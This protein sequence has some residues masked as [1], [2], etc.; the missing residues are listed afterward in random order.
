MKKNLSYWE[1]E[2]IKFV[3]NKKLKQKGKT[4]Y[5]IHKEKIKKK[6]SLEK[7][8]RIYQKEYIRRYNKNRRKNDINFKILYNYR[9]R[10]RQALKQNRK[11]K[12]TEKLI[13]CNIDFLKYHLQKQFKKGMT[14]Q[15]YGKWHID[16][17]RP[18][19]SFDL[20]KASEQR[21]CF[22]YKNLQPLWAKENIRKRNKWKQILNKLKFIFS[23]LL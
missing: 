11:S 16:H 7:R 19:N 15:N 20:S 17:I 2:H 9:V 21:K 4:Y 10:L 18:C 23:L 3:K 22:N 14:W 13:G 12:T 1:I 6:Y 8:K 5:D